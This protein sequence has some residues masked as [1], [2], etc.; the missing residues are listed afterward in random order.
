[1]ARQLG[2]SETSDHGSQDCGLSLVENDR[3]LQDLLVDKEDSGV[4]M[5]DCA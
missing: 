2:T 1:M 5:E 3:I 4:D